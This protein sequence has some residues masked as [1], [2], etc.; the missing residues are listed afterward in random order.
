MPVRADTRTIV[1]VAEYA[2]EIINKIDQ[3]LNRLCQ[4]TKWLT[5][6]IT[7]YSVFEGRRRARTHVKRQLSEFYAFD[8]LPAHVR[9][10]STRRA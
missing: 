3:Y 9:R 4:K 5:L 2:S 8:K 10:G 6:W 1:A 7:L